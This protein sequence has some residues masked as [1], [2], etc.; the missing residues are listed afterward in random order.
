MTKFI[1]SFF[2]SYIIKAKGEDKMKKVKNYLE[3]EKHWFDIDARF[4]ENGDLFHLHRIKEGLYSFA[5]DQKRYLLNTEH[6]INLDNDY[7][8]E[9]ENQSFVLTS[10]GKQKTLGRR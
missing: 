3:V 9:V 7:E 4:I 5:L 10:N 1:F 8:F 2:P 6:D